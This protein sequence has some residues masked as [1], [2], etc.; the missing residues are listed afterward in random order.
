MVAG[1]PHAPA[2]R[3]A[4]VVL[5]GLAVKAAGPASGYQRSAFGTPWADVDSNGCDTLDDILR[6]D[7]TLIREKRGTNG[8]QILSGSLA[9]PYTGKD[10]PF[11][12]GGASEVD[13]DHV[14][15]LGAAW[16]TGARTWTAPKRVQLANDP[17][18]L[19]AVSTVTV[20]AKGDRDSGAWLPPNAGFRCHYVARQI[21]VKAKYGA[22]VTPG[23]R[24]AMVRVL[25]RCPTERVP[26]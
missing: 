10:V 15:A 20:R 24:A 9:D 14:V 22:W 12:R 17:L 3:L 21:A 2:A 7:L 6:R 4:T 11:H 13:V 26:S 1:S 25:Q 8:C 23:E 16:E 18:N 19:L 5:S